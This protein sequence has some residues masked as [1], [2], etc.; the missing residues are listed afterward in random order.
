MPKSAGLTLLWIE[1]AYDGSAARMHLDGT[2]KR[3]ASGGHTVGKILANRSPR[4]GTSQWQRFGRISTQILRGVLAARR[5]V[6]IA[7]YHP[8]LL[9]VMWAWS[10]RKGRVILLIQGS[11]DDVSSNEH[12]WFAKVPGMRWLERASLRSAAGFVAVTEGLAAQVSRVL[13]EDAS[14]KPLLILPNGIS[15]P[16]RATSDAVAPSDHRYAAFVGSLAVWQGIDVMLRAT[17]SEY[18]PRD[19]VLRVAGDGVEADKVRAAVGP[20]VEYLGFLPHKSAEALIEQSVCLLALKDP[21]ASAG[22]GGYWPFK[23]LEGAALGVPVIVSDAPRLP[24]MA[25]ALQC[26]T[27]VEYGNHDAVARAVAQFNDDLALRE[28]FGELGRAN[29]QAFTWEAGAKQLSDFVGQFS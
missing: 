1:A 24:E 17:Q 22:S 8:L 25:A 9:P 5:G 2:L 3:L 13:G 23:V 15:L 28:R 10:L 7:R 6:L 4:L 18:W 20:R 16:L 19:V 26:C 14:A 27:V 12:K 29:V 11:L 21:D